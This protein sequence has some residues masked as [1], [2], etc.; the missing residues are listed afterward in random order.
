MIN[1]GME[2]G[3]AETYDRLEEH[4][5]TIASRSAVAAPALHTAGR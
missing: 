4:L 2:K 1:S 3:A 5:R